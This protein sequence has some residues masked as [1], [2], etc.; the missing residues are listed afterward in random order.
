MNSC[1][2]NRTLCGR[3]HA[4]CLTAQLMQSLH[5]MVFQ[6]RIEG[7]QPALAVARI[8]DAQRTN[9]RIPVFEHLLDSQAE[10]AEQILVDLLQQEQ[11]AR[12]HGRP[13]QRIRLCSRQPIG[14]MRRCQLPQRRQV[15]QRPGAEDALTTTT[16][17]EFAFVVVRMAIPDLMEIDAACDTAGKAFL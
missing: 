15:V 8:G 7:G 5:K 6:R 13:G 1:R 2:F 9:H 10:A 11:A 3:R 16:D 14:A 12:V 17:P 4:F